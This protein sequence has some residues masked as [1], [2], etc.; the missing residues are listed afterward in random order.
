MKNMM[1]YQVAESRFALIK[2]QHL[3]QRLLSK[4]P[5]SDEFLSYSTVIRMKLKFL[6]VQQRFPFRRLFNV[7]PKVC[8]SSG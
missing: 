6:S 5:Y 4:I 2:S 1:T 3:T 8:V 7:K